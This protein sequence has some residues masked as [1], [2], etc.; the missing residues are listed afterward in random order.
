MITSLYCREEEADLSS[1]DPHTVAG[2]LKSYL[3]ELPEHVLTNQ[4]SGEFE[5]AA[6]RHGRNEKIKVKQKES[7]SKLHVSTT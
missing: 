1:Y 5:D 4:L 3:R 6:A 2:V 7:H